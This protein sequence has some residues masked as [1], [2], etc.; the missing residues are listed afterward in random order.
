MHELEE[1]RHDHFIHF[2]CIS[3]LLLVSCARIL[4][5]CARIV[6]AAFCRRLSSSRLIVGL[7]CCARRCTV[8]EFA[9]FVARFERC[10]LI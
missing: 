10:V 9:D 8:R 2:L 3:V 4:F 7:N 6:A 1:G 5:L